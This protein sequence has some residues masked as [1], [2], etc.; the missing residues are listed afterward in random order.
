MMS[1][2][3]QHDEVAALPFRKLRLIYYGASPMSPTLLQRAMD[4]FGCGFINAF[5]AGTEAGLQTVMTVADHKRALAGEVELLGSIGKPGHGVAL[6]LVD[7]DMNDVPS[8]VVGEI[9]TRS[10][11][12][13]DGYLDLPDETGRAFRDGWLRAGDMAY[14]AENGYLYLHGRKKDMIIRGGENIYPRCPPTPA[15]RFSSGSC[16]S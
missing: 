7:D 4:V 10:D 8:G 1:I 6:R 12:L 2:L 16:A 5:G 3:L 14:L 13:M 9:A 15:A 11:M